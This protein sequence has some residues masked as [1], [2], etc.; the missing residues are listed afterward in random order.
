MNPAAIP[1]FVSTSPKRTVEYLSAGAPVSM[2]DHWFEIAHLNHF[3]IRRRFEV[4]QQ[5]TARSSWKDAVAGEIG[6]GHGLLQRQCEDALDL[7]VDGFDLNEWALERNI[8]R[9]SRVCC[10]NI[11]DRASELREH[12]DVIFLFDVIE[13]IEDDRAFVEAA[14]FHLKKGGRLIVNV[15]A[16]QALFSA[17]DRAAGHVR[18]YSPETLA[19]LMETAGLQ[20]QLWTYWGLSMVPLLFVRKWM[21]ER[22]TEPDE[23]LRAGFKPGSR[24]SNAFLGALCKLERIPQHRT[25]SSLMLVASK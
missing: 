12:Y 5:I 20:M 24:A 1:L 18:R 19:R 23:I 10:Y 2:G 7:C 8:S 22:L 15:P 4:L 17:Y 21:L 14:L 13:H 9:R 11:F 6:C 16:T 25:G 3:W